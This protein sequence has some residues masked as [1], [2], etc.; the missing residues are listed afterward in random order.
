MVQQRDP[1]AACLSATAS[2]AEDKLSRQTALGQADGAERV[3]TYEVG[4]RKSGRRQSVCTQLW[5]L[6]AYRGALAGSVNVVVTPELLPGFPTDV[7]I[8][9]TVRVYGY[10]FKLQGYQPANPKPNAPPLAAPMIVG[11]VEWVRFVTPTNPAERTLS[12]TSSW[13]AG[14]VPGRRHGDRLLGSTSAR[15]KK[16]S[17]PAAVDHWPTAAARRLDDVALHDDEEVEPDDHEQLCLPPPCRKNSIGCGID[18]CLTQKHLVC[19]TAAQ[20]PT[21][22]RIRYKNRRRSTCAEVRIPEADLCETTSPPPRLSP[23]RS[24]SSSRPAFLFGGLHRPGND[25]RRTDADPQDATNDLLAATDTI[26]YSVVVDGTGRIL[27]PGIYRL[28]GHG[29]ARYKR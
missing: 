24:V 28:R 13:A 7:D 23:P 20:S 25:R 9:E 1:P 22:C 5:K 3:V 4:K 12:F 6:L 15:R 26:R 18:R 8:A 10:F 29:S 16:N 17:P 11:R 27:F 21:A 2:T 14:G 19:R